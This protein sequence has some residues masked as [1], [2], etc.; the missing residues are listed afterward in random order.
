MPKLK[1]PLQLLNS[2]DF[3][4]IPAALD[5]RTV[6]LLLKKPRN[7][8]SALLSGLAKKD[9]FQYAYLQNNVG[10]PLKF[11]APKSIGNLEDLNKRKQFYALILLLKLVIKTGGEVESFDKANNCL[12]VKKDEYKRRTLVL[13]SFD[14]SVEN[15]VKNFKISNGYDVKNFNPFCLFSAQS[16]G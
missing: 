5:A 14:G 8:I 1:K 9:V 15:N 12:I 16:T 4:Q 13:D 11:Y 3:L 6:G 2:S 10:R 7:K